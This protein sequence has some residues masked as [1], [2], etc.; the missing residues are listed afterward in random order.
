MSR[1]AEIRYFRLKL[2]HTRLKDH[3]NRIMPTEFPTPICD[4]G[5]DRETVE[6]FLLNCSLHLNQRE[7]MIGKIERGFIETNTPHIYRKV[8]IHTLLGNNSSLSPDMRTKITSAVELYLTSTA[9][10]TQI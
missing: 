4:C 6:H 9:D 2:G 3:M 5:E 8:N 1:T 10:L 7:I